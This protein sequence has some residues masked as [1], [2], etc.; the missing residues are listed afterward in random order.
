M[1]PGGK[2]TIPAAVY[3]CVVE[4]PLLSV[5]MSTPISEVGIFLPIFSINAATVY[6]EIELKYICGTST[7]ISCQ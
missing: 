7:I 3:F 5:S 4:W 6:L 2:L 1:E